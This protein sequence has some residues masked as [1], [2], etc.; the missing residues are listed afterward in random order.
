MILDFRSC[1]ACGKRSA[2]L[3]RV[4]WSCWERNT[5]ATCPQILDQPRPG[6]ILW[7]TSSTGL[8]VQHIATAHIS[9]FPTLQ[10]FCNCSSHG[11]N[12]SRSSPS[13]MGMV[14][15]TSYR[16]PFDG[17]SPQAGP[18][19][20]IGFPEQLSKHSCEQPWSGSHI[21]GPLIICS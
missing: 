9:H 7:S 16:T 8:L 5:S 15:F 14:L 17:Y 10:A 11:S 4:R 18:K 1:S 21:S 3:L 6:S 2:K 13:Y 20:Q 12:L 19:L